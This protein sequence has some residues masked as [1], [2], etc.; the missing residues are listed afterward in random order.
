MGE[1]GEEALSSQQSA[2]GEALSACDSFFSVERRE[3][4]QTAKDEPWI[5]KI[6]DALINAWSIATQFLRPDRSYE[7]D[8]DRTFIWS[9]VALMGRLSPDQIRTQINTFWQIMCGKSNGK[10]EDLYSSAAL[11]WTGKARKPETASV[12][13]AR[14]ERQIATPGAHAEAELGLMEIELPAPSLAIAQIF[15]LDECGAPRI[16]HEH[17]SA[18]TNPEV[19]P[20]RKE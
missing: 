20:A 16:V 1:G 10:L 7:G 4:F 15:E 13:L 2:L 8:S 12:V 5:G 6:L 14:R 11:L 18:A 3:S 19:S 9:Y 17:L